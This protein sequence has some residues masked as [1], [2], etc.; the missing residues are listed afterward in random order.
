MRPVRDR[1]PPLLSLPPAGRRISRGSILWDPDWDLLDRREHPRH[2]AGACRCWLGWWE[3]DELVAQAVC[4]LDISRGGAALI[5]PA[6]WGPPVG[7]PVWFCMRAGGH[8]ECLDASVAGVEPCSPGHERIRLAFREPLPD[9]LLGMATRRPG[10]V[11][12]AEA[13]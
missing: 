9:R 11:S 6:G 8:T 1:P 3:G 2:A 5:G 4:L 13:G 12:P 7:S 10:D